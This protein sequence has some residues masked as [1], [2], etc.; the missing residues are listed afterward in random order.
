MKV[1]VS[2]LSN[3]IKAIDIV[4]ELNKS[5][6]DYIH[7]DIMDGKFVP[8]KTWTYGEIKKI[9]SYSNKKLDV[10]FMVLNPEK[11]LEEYALLNTEYFTFHYECIKDIEKMIN[12]VKSYGLKVGISIKPNTNVKVL[13]PYLK[14]IDLVLIMSV[15]P[16]KS[17]QE[18]IDSSLER[19]NELKSEIIRQNSN[20]LIEAD[21]GI[22]EETGL[23]CKNSG[24]DILVSASYIH[25]D[26]INN[27]KTLKNL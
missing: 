2:I 22:N 20:T 3:S 6:A 13:F 14:D 5:N 7:L 27:I 17:G 12:L 18:F 24:V 19:I 8:N 11:Y 23:L 9:I 26:I 25:K 1:S 16:G 10:H 21:G 4:K 15:E